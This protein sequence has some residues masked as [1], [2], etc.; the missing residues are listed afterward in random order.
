MIACRPAARFGSTISAPSP[1]PSPIRRTFARL[2]GEPV[3]ALGIKRSKGASDVVVAAAVKKR[4]DELKVAYPD[5]DLKLIDTSVDFTEGNYEAAIHTLFEGAALAVII[6][7]LFL[8]NFR[9]TIIVAISLPLS[10]FPAFWVMDMLGL[11][12]QPGQ[13][14]R[15]HASHRHPGR[16]RHRRDRE[17]RAAHADGQDRPIR[18][19]SKPPTKSASP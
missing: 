15:H 4:I 13:L 1:T 19:R 11:L 12:A 14:P 16:R 3:V 7:L 17:H 18:R 8:R 5:I 6:V 9:A 10:I 2:N